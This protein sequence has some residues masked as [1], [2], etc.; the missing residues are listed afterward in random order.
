MN[1]SEEIARRRVPCGPVTVSADGVCRRRLKDI[2]DKLLDRLS[3]ET[4]QLYKPPEAPKNHEIKDG[5]VIHKDVIAKNDKAAKT[6][7]AGKAKARKERE[8]AAA[9]PS[10][11]EKKKQM[12]EDAKTKVDVKIAAKNYEEKLMGNSKL[13]QRLDSKIEKR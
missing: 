6:M 7:Q 10:P 3:A 4:S 11:E 1:V 8:K 9:E 13:L 5:K 12:I 2:M